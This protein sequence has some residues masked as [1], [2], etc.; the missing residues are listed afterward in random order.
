MKIEF[1][2]IVLMLSVVLPFIVIIF[3]TSIV[4]YRLCLF[5]KKVGIYD[6]RMF[7]RIVILNPCLSNSVYDSRIL[8]LFEEFTVV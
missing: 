6:L 3:L 7:V 5:P 4:Q 2:V 8:T 1:W